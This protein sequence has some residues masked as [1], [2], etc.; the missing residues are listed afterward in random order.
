M[1][2][3]CEKQEEKKEEMLQISRAINITIMRSSAV[4]VANPCPRGKLSWLFFQQSQPHIPD[5]GNKQWVGH[6]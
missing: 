6:E 3:H 1:S 5:P 4:G 2:V